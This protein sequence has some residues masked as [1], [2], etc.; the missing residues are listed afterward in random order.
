MGLWGLQDDAAAVVREC[1]C[2]YGEMVPRPIGEALH[3]VVP[4]VLIHC[5]FMSMP[6]GYIHVLVDDASGL[7]QLTWHDRCRADDMVTK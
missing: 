4:N 3:A 6:T 7:C 1:R 5:D 2:I